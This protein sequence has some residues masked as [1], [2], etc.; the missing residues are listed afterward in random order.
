MQV[1][2]GGSLDPELA[3]R[4][5]E[6]VSAPDGHGSAPAPNAVCW[7]QDGVTSV[8]DA[9]T[10]LDTLRQPDLL[11]WNSIDAD[12]GYPRSWLNHWQRGHNLALTPN[13]VAA[14]APDQQLREY[15]RSF[16]LGATR[17]FCPAKISARQT[18][19]ELARNDHRLLARIREAGLRRTLFYY[20]EAACEDLQHRLALEPVYC[21]PSAAS[22]AAGNDKYEFARAATRYGFD[23]VDAELVNDAG[24]LRR[25]F[26]TVADQY[27]EGCILRP[28]CGAG[29]S[30]VHQVRSTD[31]AYAV[32]QRLR[33]KGDVLLMPYVPETVAVRHLAVHSI[34]TRDGIRPLLVTEQ[35]IRGGRFRG[36]MARPDWDPAEIAAILRAMEKIGPWLLDLGYVDAPVCID[37]FVSKH[38]G[39][40]RFV[41]LDPNV[42]MSG[43][44]MSW[45]VSTALS[46]SAGRSF[47]WRAERFPLI[48]RSLSICALK[49]RLGQLLLDPSRLEQGGIFPT[50]ISSL[51][52]GICASW[53]TA[54]LFAHDREHLD[55]LR[56]AVLRLG[57]L[58]R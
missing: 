12:P 48:G 15:H 35:L 34:I 36:G 18:L 41:A 56:N 5:G 58:V 11:L 43:T 24:A 19:A 37:G 46:E 4:T 13:V 27:G 33:R 54:I 32:W 2:R 10:F 30:G 14:T 40:M 29:G 28:R 47:F 6:T 39:E 22:Y 21:R 52:L 9:R 38:R 50:M 3:R 17:F 44:M 23:A 1:L 57:W 49:S 53:L 55:H 42:R 7:A 16:G 26:A 8:A 45:I 25:R 31:A 20:K 51:G